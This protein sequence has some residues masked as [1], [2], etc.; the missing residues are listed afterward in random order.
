[1]NRRAFLVLLAAGAALGETPEPRV[2]AISARKF[3][4]SPSEVTLKLGE[5]VVFELRTEDVHMGFDAP[6][7]GLNADIVPGRVARLPFTPASAG[8]FEFACDVFC[9]SGHEEM[10]G[11]IKV[12]A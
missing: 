7:L 6:A 5:P 12:L 4:F 3:E 2:V 10:S 1:V 8:E 11:V 9:G